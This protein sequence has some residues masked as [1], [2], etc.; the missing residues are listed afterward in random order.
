[1]HTLMQY[2]DFSACSTPEG[3][4]D[5]IRELVE[6][7]LLSQEEGDRIDRQSVVK[8]F[9]SEL[10]QRLRAGENL[11]REFKFSI[12]VDAQEFGEKLEGEQI[13][14]QGVVDCALMEEDGITVVDFK[15]DRVKP[16]NLDQTVERYRSQVGAYAKALERIY[17][18][19]VKESILWFFHLGTQV[20]L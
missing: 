3:V 15:T 6:R 11:L 5:Q 13:L 8:L 14:L 9:R 7:R 18:L 1:M 19:P 10:G 12:L 16:D 2:V 4:E 17:G 20:I